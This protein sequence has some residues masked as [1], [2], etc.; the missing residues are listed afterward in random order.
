[1]NLRARVSW[2][3]LMVFKPVKVTLTPACTNNN[4]TFRR[5]TRLKPTNRLIQ[6][7]SISLRVK[8][9]NMGKAANARLVNKHKIYVRL[10]FTFAFYARVVVKVNLSMGHTKRAISNTL[11][12]GEVRQSKA[13]LLWRKNVISFRR[14]ATLKSALVYKKN[15]DCRMLKSVSAVTTATNTGDSSDGG[16]ESLRNTGRR[17]RAIAYLL[18]SVALSLRCVPLGVVR[19]MFDVLSM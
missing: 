3:P 17:V 5:R 8:L 10:N 7:L 4:F 11:K 15:G 13:R 1:M 19:L 6:R 2:Q 18:E 14:I 16:R 9:L 12:V